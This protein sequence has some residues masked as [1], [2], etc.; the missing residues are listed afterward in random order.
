VHARAA[1]DASIDG[2]VSVRRRAA[3]YSSIIDTDRYLECLYR[4]VLWVGAAAA[5]P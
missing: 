1:I 4:A 2:G 3:I 5:E